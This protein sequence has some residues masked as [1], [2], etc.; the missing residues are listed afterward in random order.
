MYTYIYMYICTYI[1]S[2][3]LRL[4]LPIYRPYVC[5]QQ[6]ARRP[7]TD[8]IFKRNMSILMGLFSEHTGL[9]S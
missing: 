1:S 6:P 3:L 5:A 4:S 8:S 2:R 7:A 9:F